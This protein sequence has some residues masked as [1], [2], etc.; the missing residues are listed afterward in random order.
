[1]VLTLDSHCGLRGRD[2]LAHFAV[3][4]ELNEQFT[5]GAQLNL[6]P[7]PFSSSSQF[8]N[9]YPKHYPQTNCILNICYVINRLS[10]KQAL[11]C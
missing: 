6:E 9:N 3:Y 7:D 5:S 1:M 11:A 10:A 2:F 4:P 8:F